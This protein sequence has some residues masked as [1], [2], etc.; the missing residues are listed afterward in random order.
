MSDFD[1]QAEK[2]RKKLKKQKENDSLCQYE[3]SM[4]CRPLVVFTRCSF[5]SLPSV[6]P[7]NELIDTY[8]RQSLPWYE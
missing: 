7:M 4:E 8:D 1:A 3:F 2:V 5:H 6:L